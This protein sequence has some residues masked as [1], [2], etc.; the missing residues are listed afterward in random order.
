MSGTPQKRAWPFGDR[1]ENS[2]TPTSARSLEQ[3]GDKNTCFGTILGEKARLIQSMETQVLSSQ[4]FT[5]VR[6]GEFFSLEIAT[7]KVAR[8]TKGIS[9]KLHDFDNGPQVRLLA[10]VPK[11]DRNDLMGTRNVRTST[12]LSV[13]I[14]VYG[15]RGDAKEIGTILSKSG[16]F[17]QRPDYVLE[18]T[19]YYN[20]H[21]FR[22]DGFAEQVPIET[23]LSSTED[24]VE[25]QGHAWSGEV[26]ADDTA[27]V[28]S[29][30]DSLSHHACLR[31]I[32]VD[33]RIKS[34][35]LPHQKE[36]IDFI[37]ERETGTIPSELSLWKYN[38]IDADDP[39]YQHVFTKAKSPK[40]QEAEG[41]IIAD[42][43][44]L[45]KSLVILTTIAGS[46]DRAMT[47]VA[48]ENQSLSTQ[49]LAK[50]PSAATL[51]LAPSSLLID[52]WLNEIRKYAFARSNV[53]W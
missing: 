16:I 44:G 34:T 51:I 15:T 29:I 26:Q 41:G 40:Q 39:F 37:S 3:V 48:S 47:F 45:G 7:H 10:Y 14:N 1:E 53:F 42:E 52:N 21:L 36:A 46:L 22:L 8:L 38:D 2:T 4:S 19:E 35:L 12:L 9:R 49:Q 13:E 6:E 17:L 24:E 30:L 31:D 43:M 25:T 11:K 20:P 5:V 32:P 27:V 23:P 50:A 28:N 18:N 33:R